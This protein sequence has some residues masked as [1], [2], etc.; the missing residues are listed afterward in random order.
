MPAPWGLLMRNPRPW[1]WATDSHTPSRAPLA[2]GYNCQAAMPQPH[3]YIFVAQM[4]I[5]C[6]KASGRLRTGNRR[7]QPSAMCV[8][9]KQPRRGC[10]LKVEGLMFSVECKISLNTPRSTLC[11]ASTRPLLLFCAFRKPHSACVGLLRTQI[12]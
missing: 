5:P 3:G 10:A 12:N 4:G 8:T 6:E 7:L 11:A 2:R 1:P 9:T